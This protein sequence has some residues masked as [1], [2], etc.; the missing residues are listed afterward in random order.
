MAQNE[1]ETKMEIDSNK[2]ALLEEELKKL[3]AQNE[4]LV[5][6][7]SLELQKEKDKM[8]LQYSIEL[9]AG[10]ANKLLEQRNP[11]DFIPVAPA[12]QKTASDIIQKFNDLL[13]HVEEFSV[14]PS[15]EYGMQLDNDFLPETTS[16][17][18]LTEM[19]KNIA[20][21]VTEQHRVWDLVA[22][23]IRKI[24]DDYSNVQKLR[25]RK[26][27]Y[28]R[29]HSA[30]VRKQ[31]RKREDKQIA[32]KAQYDDEDD[33]SEADSD[34]HEVDPEVEPDGGERADLT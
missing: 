8:S 32:L 24:R 1:K 4:H 12:E 9:K 33:G 22:S 19:K 16:D 25:H 15:A 27:K 31:K 2:T 14:L 29:K 34:N 30:A 3:Q 11:Y 20:A 5:S 13:Q 10:V 21:K 17:K 7:Y 18:G 26:I 28:K 23:K 6:T